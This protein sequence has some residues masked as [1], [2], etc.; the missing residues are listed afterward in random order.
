MIPET[1][2]PDPWSAARARFGKLCPLL[3]VIDIIE[4]TDE[5][6]PIAALEDLGEMLL[7][8]CTLIK[9]DRTLEHAE[10]LHIIRTADD[11]WRRTREPD[12]PTG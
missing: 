7:D 4:G 10:R 1:S 9:T 6:Q 8:G 11:A 2:Q 3:R 12:K 5:F